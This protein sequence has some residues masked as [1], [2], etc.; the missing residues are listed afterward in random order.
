MSPYLPDGADDRLVGSLRNLVCVGALRVWLIVLYGNM[1]KRSTYPVGLTSMAANTE[2]L[3]VGH[4]ANEARQIQFLK[5]LW[6]FD[7][8]ATLPLD[9]LGP[10]EQRLHEGI[11]GAKGDINVAVAH[12]GTLRGIVQFLDTVNCGLSIFGKCKLHIAVHYFSSWTFHDHKDGKPIG[13][14]GINPP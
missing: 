9:A 2:Q 7:G 11:L 8:A 14:A 6:N 12:T 13:Q 3:L 4:E 1:G 10:R 5:V